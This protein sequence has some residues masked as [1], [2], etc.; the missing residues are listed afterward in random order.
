MAEY[1]ISFQKK[2]EKKLFAN[3]LYF[4]D[5]AIRF[6]NQKLDDERRIVVCIVNLQTALELCFKYYITKEYG[7]EKIIAPLKHGKKIEDLDAAELQ[8]ILDKLTNN[9]VKV[10]EFDE[11]KNFLKGRP[12]ISTK[13]NRYMDI[14]ERLQKY[15][16]SL[17]H[18]VYNFTTSEKE[19]VE[20]EIIIAITRI[21][22]F[23]MSEHDKELDIKMFEYLNR[24]QYEMFIE[25]QKVYYEYEDA[26]CEEYGDVYEC[27]ICL[28][29]LMTPKKYCCSCFTRYD[30]PNIYG[31][32]DCPMCNLK[33]TFLYDALNYRYNDMVDLLCVSCGYRDRLAKKKL[34]KL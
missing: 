34:Q 2:I 29:R 28:K 27:P 7:L 10:R 12:D 22:D 8:E 11:T 32:T 26:L 31:F 20:K 5:E 19:A 24:E 30:D 17:V 6:F 3:S 15:R 9:S 18:F 13:I 1:F 23:L 4:M 16:N 33:N 14:I 21:A 25:N